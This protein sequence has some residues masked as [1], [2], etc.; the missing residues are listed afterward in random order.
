MRLLFAHHQINEAD[1]ETNQDCDSA[2]WSTEKSQP[3]QR[4]K[5]TRSLIKSIVNKY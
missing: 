1:N 4:S 2:N 3:G 5:C